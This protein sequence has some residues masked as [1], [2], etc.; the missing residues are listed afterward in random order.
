MRGNCTIILRSHHILSSPPILEICGNEE[1]TNPKISTKRLFVSGNA[2]AL[3]SMSETRLPSATCRPPLDLYSGA[4]FSTRHPECSPHLKL[5]NTRICLPSFQARSCKIEFTRSV[6]R[7]CKMS[8]FEPCCDLTQA[9]KPA[10]RTR[11]NTRSHHSNRR[12]TYRRCRLFPKRRHSRQPRSQDQGPNRC[13]LQGPTCWYQ[14]L[15]PRNRSGSP[16][17][18]SYNLVAAELSPY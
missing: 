2:R 14:D 16:D 11:F 13:Y 3:R 18:R 4:S 10:S 1:E 7:I 8:T 15:L 17:C 5:T 12:R 9:G 6:S